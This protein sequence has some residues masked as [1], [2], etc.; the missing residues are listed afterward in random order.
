M[1]FYII[2]VRIKHYEKM[3]RY[4]TANKT[5]L[6]ANVLIQMNAKHVYF[7]TKMTDTE[8]NCL[9]KEMKKCKPRIECVGTAPK[10]G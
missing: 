8:L 3:L 5:E 4:F 7:S 10:R 9:I 2:R 1:K 6:M